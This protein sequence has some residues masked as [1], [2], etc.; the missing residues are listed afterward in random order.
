MNKISIL[1]RSGLVALGALAM[2]PAH[3]AWTLNMNEGVTDLTS[4]VFGLHM[5]I[6]WICV[7]IKHRAENADADDHADPEDQHVQTEDVIGQVGH[8]AA[9]VERPFGVG[10][11][12]GQRTERPQTPTRQH[13]DLLHN[14]S[15]YI[16]P[17][18]PTAARSR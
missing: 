5:L 7:V 6:F 4:K 9:H 1:S 2:S 16:R 8:A 10:R 14:H 11:R 3:A 17:V 13:A 12:H 18:R 15:L